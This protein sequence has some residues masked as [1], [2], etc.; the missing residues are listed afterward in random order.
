MRIDLNVPFAEKDEAKRL[1]AWWDAGRRTWYVKDVE[2]L[3]PFQRWFKKR[4]SSSHEVQHMPNPKQ[5][6][7]RAAQIGKLM[8]P[9]F[10]QSAVYV[11]HCGCYDMP[12]WEDCCHTADLGIEDEQIA[13]LRSI[14]SA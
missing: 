11:P 10:T 4:Q 1:G 14:M 9:V 13:H 8:R 7:K 3:T 5:Q 6:K 12:P 2:D